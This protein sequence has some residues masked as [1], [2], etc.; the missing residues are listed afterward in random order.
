MVGNGG[1]LGMGAVGIVM[2]YP[3]IGRV[4]MVAGKYRRHSTDDFVLTNL[5][6]QSIGILGLSGSNLHNP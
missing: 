2:A 3:A 1:G 4:A 6:F 5:V